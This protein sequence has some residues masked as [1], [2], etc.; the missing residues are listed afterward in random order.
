M[1]DRQV[2]LSNPLCFLVNKLGKTSLRV[3]KSIITDFYEALDLSAAKCQLLDDINQL[4]ISDKADGMDKL[5][6]I[7]RRRDGENRIARE[8]DDILTLL[9]T[10]DE[11][12]LSDYL[13]IYVSDGP[14]KMPSAHLVDG[15]LKLLMVR[16]DKLDDKIEE[17][18]TLLAAIVKDAR[19]PPWWTEWTEVNSAAVNKAIQPST[20]MVGKTT[21]PTSMNG[22]DTAD[23]A[24]QGAINNTHT[25]HES[26]AGWGLTMSRPHMHNNYRSVDTADETCGDSTDEVAYTEQKSRKKRRRERSRY[27]TVEPAVAHQSLVSNHQPSYATVTANPPRSMRPRRGPLL[28]G[29]SVSRNPSTCSITAAKS[30]IKKAVFCIDNVDSSSSEKELKDF[31]TSLSVTVLSIFEVQPRKRRTDTQVMIDANKFDRKAFRLCIDNNDRGRLLDADK[32]P[33]HISVWE[34]YFKPTN[35]TN[36]EYIRS[37][38]PQRITS[39]GSSTELVDLPEEM[40]AGMSNRQLENETDMDAT[41]ITAESSTATE[42]GSPNLHVRDG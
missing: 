15:D 39:Q 13:P 26:V 7:P 35:S 2:V 6:H 29:K 14:D 40:Q 21:L 25:H 9:I 41:I 4:E 38:K 28:V 31:V 19:A 24:D 11:R 12:K 22:T 42:S 27:E 34:W 37:D 33:A 36:K 32:W 16:L 8:V 20:M 18:R 23:T 5:P 3:L 10:L 30:S 1:A 17:F